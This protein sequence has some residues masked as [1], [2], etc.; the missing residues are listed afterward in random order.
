MKDHDSTSYPKST[1]GL[2]CQCGGPFITEHI[3]RGSL[4]DERDSYRVHC[5]WCPAS[6]R[7]LSH[8]YCCIIELTEGMGLRKAQHENKKRI[9]K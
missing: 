1:H 3:I 2:L 5:E 6:S 7:W 4:W 8:E 9:R